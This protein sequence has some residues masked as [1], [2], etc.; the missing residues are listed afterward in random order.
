MRPQA[1]SALCGRTPNSYRQITFFGVSNALAVHTGSMYPARIQGPSAARPL[2]RERVGRLLLLYQFD[3][4]ARKLYLR[5]NE[6][7][8]LQ[9]ASDAEAKGQHGRLAFIR[10][11]VLPT[12]EADVQSVSRVLF[13]PSEGKKSNPKSMRARTV[14]HRLHE[15][16]ELNEV[17]HTP[18]DSPPTGNAVGG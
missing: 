5:L 4:K 15:N 7:K 10:I 14:L 8:G 18:F 3:L 2:Q 6:A 16:I 11:S 12:A 9:L 17:C 13:K 1:A